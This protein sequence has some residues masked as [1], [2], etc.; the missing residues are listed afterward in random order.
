MYEKELKELVYSLGVGDCGFAF[1]GDCLPD[2]VPGRLVNAVSVCY[3][4]SAAVLETITDRPSI[5]Y[6]QHYRAVN[7]RLDSV[8]LDICRFIEQKG[9]SAFPIAASQS[10]N[11]EEE[12]YNGV[13]PHKTAAVRAGMG[14]IGMNNLFIDRRCGIGV[15]LAT[16]LTDLPLDTSAGMSPHYC[17]GCG[18]C[19]SACPAGALKGVVWKEGM[20]REDI[21]DPKKCSEWM[22][23]YKDIGRGAVCGLCMKA[24]PYLTE[25]PEDRFSVL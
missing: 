8:C 17:T 10:R 13:F 24:C 15:R 7:A 16:V 5:M 9:Y 18:K 3:K 25:K 6:F 11:T 23:T 4:L 19:V 20:K 2:D 1:V 22:K 12:K 21:F 14:S